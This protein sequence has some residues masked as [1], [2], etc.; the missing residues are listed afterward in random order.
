VKLLEDELK[1]AEEDVKRLT[2]EYMRESGALRE[3]ELRNERLNGEMD[4]MAKEV[5]EVWQS[6]K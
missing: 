1:I 2:D 4:M 6:I 3:E 5:F